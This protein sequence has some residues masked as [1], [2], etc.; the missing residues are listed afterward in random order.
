GT[1]LAG[2]SGGPFGTAIAI[3]FFYTID[4]G[5]NLIGV[6]ATYWQLIITGTLLLFAVLIDRTQ[7]LLHRR[8]QIIHTISAAAHAES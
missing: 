2:G 1:A 3:I 5:L 6:T 8:R 4:K 7:L